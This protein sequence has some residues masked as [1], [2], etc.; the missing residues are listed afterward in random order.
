MQV[1]GGDAAPDTQC[2]L[3][4]VTLGLRFSR[5]G[6]TGSRTRARV[7]MWGHVPSSALKL[8]LCCLFFFFFFGK[9]RYN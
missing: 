7:V 4:A 2:P 1:A 5:S 8:F 3:T 9:W 6:T